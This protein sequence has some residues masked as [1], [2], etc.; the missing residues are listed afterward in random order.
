MARR[1][2]LLSLTFAAACGGSEPPPIVIVPPPP[3]F[4]IAPPPPPPPPVPVAVEP[5]PAPASPTELALRDWAAVTQCQS[6]D[7]HPHGGLQSFWCHRPVRMTLSFVESTTGT[8]IFSSGPH[9]G[10]LTLD[11]ANDFGHYNPDFVK[12]LV[13]KG[14]PSALDSPA[15]A[16]TQGAYDKHLKPLAEIFYYT[17]QKTECFESEKKAYGDLIAKKKLPK[18]YYERWFYYMNPYFCEKAK[19]GLAQ[20]QSF[21]A[22]SDNGFDGGIDG[23]VT[24]TVVGFWLRRALDGTKDS[25]AEGLKKLLAAYEP[26]L[27][28][29]PYRAPNGAAIKDAIAKGMKAAALC[30]G[31]ASVTIRIQTDGTMTG[32]THRARGP[33]D[34]NARCIEN[35][36]SGTVPAFDGSEMHFSRNVTGK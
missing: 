35:A 18:D 14:A 12:W 9:K 15:R 19:A 36:F 28:A 31:K 25:F 20:D 32:S 7:Y 22:F 11:A 24:K 17:L 27:V 13:D 2:A 8:T 23:N 16:A 34:P 5:P 3:T 33:V 1:L 10:D 26:G 6:Y 21:A 4:D 30:T 29:Q